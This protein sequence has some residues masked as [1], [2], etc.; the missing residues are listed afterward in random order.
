MYEY[1]VCKCVMY[2]CM[3]VC[4]SIKYFIIWCGHIDHWMAHTLDQM[5]LQL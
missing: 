4:Q 2:V 1:A 3:Y 5:L